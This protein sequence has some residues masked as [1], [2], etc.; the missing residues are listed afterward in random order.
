[1]LKRLP[2]FIIILALAGWLGWQVARHLVATSLLAFRE[3]AAS[4]AL[5]VAY[6]P[7]SAL[8]W[9]TQGKYWLYR[10]D[11]PNTA[12]GIEALQRAVALSPHDYRYHL[13]LGRG[14]AAS[15]QFAA[16]AS[17]LQ[18][19]MQLA[20]RHFETHWAYANFALRANQREAALNSFRRALE[21][22]GQDRGYGYAT[23]ISSAHNAYNALVG[24]YGFDPG[25]LE[26]ITPDNGIAQ[27]HLVSFLARQASLELALSKWRSLPVA[28]AAL[29]RSLLFQL[30]SE[31]QQAGRW[32]D[33][34]AVWSRLLAH[35]NQPNEDATNLLTNASFEYAPLNE[36]YAALAQGFDWQIEGHSEIAAERT[37]TQG[38]AGRHSLRLRLVARPTTAFQHVTQR[39][40]V[41]PG[42]S[43]RLRFYVKANE[44]P[45]AAPY[46]EITD[47]AQPQLFRVRVVLPRE[48]ADWQAQSL[49]FTVPATTNVLSLRL[50]VP[51]IAVL[52]L[53]R[54][55]T[56][57]LDDVSLLP[58]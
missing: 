21:L 29:Y 38:Y 57:W 55:N 51:M 10:A 34:R 8:A 23:E 28:D 30:L 56:A 20:P 11:P 6:A 47:A 19:A 40:I 9:A 52:D 24:A 16:A 13:E 53:N 31:T 22:S 36:R 27:T 5:A 7:H 18:Q 25:A 14:L 44:L 17:A 37:E 1:M 50:C 4:R 58:E 2:L 54:R 46:W 3:D 49:R 35:E 42:Q 15:R 33:A 32:T 45:E 48:T 41:T 39:A 12:Q 43:Y 26:R